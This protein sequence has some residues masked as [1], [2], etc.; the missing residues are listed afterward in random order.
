MKLQVVP[1]QEKDSASTNREEA[2]SSDRMVEELS[3]STNREEVAPSDPTVE[4][5]KLQNH[6]LE[7]ELEL[8]RAREAELKRYIRSSANCVS[9]TVFLENMPQQL[10]WLSQCKYGAHR[11][12]GGAVYSSSKCS[13]Y[14]V[15]SAA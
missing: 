4:E 15:A 3:S 2:A 1:S 5:L 10:G 11:E 14:I 6:A 13:T 8:Y 9:T 12:R 7:Q